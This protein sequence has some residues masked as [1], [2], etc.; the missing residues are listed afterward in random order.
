MVTGFTTT[1]AAV[2]RTSLRSFPSL[3]FERMIDKEV[4]IERDIRTQ[5][6]LAHLFITKLILLLILILLE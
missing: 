1:F 2:Y 3:D 5:Y 6:A 4:I